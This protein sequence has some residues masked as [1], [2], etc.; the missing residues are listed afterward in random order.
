M[1]KQLDDEKQAMLAALIEGSEDAIISK[2][3][4]SRITSWN[5]AAERMFGYTEAEMVGQ[6]I[7]ILIPPDRRKEEDQIIASLKRGERV[8]HF[9]TIRVTKHGRELHISLTIS[10]IRAADGTIIGAS[11]IARDITRQRLNEERLRIVNELAQS[12]NAK[13]EVDAIL[14]V[15]TDASTRLCGASFGAFF[16]NKVD[17]KGESYML[18][19]LSGAPREAFDK[20]GM[21]RN[22]AVFNP[23]FEGTAIVRSDD[24]TKDPRY[25]HNSPH[26]GMPKGHLPVVSYLAVPVRSQS[27][28]VVGG[29]FFGHPKPAMF[30]EEHEQLV[31]SIASQAAIA[32]ENAK[33]LQEVNHLNKRKDEFIGFASHELKTP[34]TTL[35]GY[36]QIARAGNMP[37]E[38]LFDKMERQVERLEGIISD[39][40]DISRIHA[41]RLDLQFSRTSLSNLIKESVELV[42]PDG[43]EVRIQYPTEDVEVNVDGQKIS[44]VLVNILSNAVKY[45]SAAT[46]IEVTASIMG[47]EIQISF[48]D[49]GPGIAPEDLR[50]I[51]N[52]YY[53]AFSQRGKG[54]GVGLGLYIAK[55]ILEAHSGRIWAESEVGKG[56]VFYVV[57]PIERR[58]VATAPK[59]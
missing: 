45:S 44:Q 27:G 13:L 41:G 56:S 37:V 3:L 25:G 34:L 2:D 52:Q 20:F 11:K 42:D 24:I 19:A 28:V 6:L 49:K 5:K 36:I 38:S 17:E 29:L 26:Q 18:Y 23:T 55:E 12:I 21:P 53:Q 31:I 40:L 59:M 16:Y 33:L 22:T 54:R 32:L 4:S 7:H 35:K 43:H 58:I 57:F 9:E 39:L 46:V 47:D 15:V 30:T 50:Q 8:E 51:F 10:P 1:S 48:R 14:Q